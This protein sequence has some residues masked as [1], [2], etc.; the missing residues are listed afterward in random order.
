MNAAGN[1]GR[2]DLSGQHKAVEDASELRYWLK[3]KG[4]MD[5]S[6]QHKAAEDGSEQSTA[7]SGGAFLAKRCG[8]LLYQKIKIIES[9]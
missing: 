4:R 2:M 7:E 3:V 1:I 9:K 6:G 8:G 5:L